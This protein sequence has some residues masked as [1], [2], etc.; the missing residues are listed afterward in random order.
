M[1]GKTD[2]SDMIQTMDSGDDR[3]PELLKEIR[4]YPNIL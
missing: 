4:D 3:Y 1:N 2:I